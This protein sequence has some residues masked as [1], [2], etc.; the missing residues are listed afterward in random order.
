MISQAATL[1]HHVLIWSMISRNFWTVIGRRRLVRGKSEMQSTIR[2]SSRRVLC[3]FNMPSGLLRGPFWPV[4]VSELDL[5]V[6]DGVLFA[7][8]RAA[9]IGELRFDDL[10]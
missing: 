10:L 8:R 1:P 9:G 3:R 7:L 5:A 6:D 2:S 4:V